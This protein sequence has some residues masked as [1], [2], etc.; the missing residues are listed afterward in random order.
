MSKRKWYAI[1]GV[2]AMHFGGIIYAWS[3]LSEPIG[4]EYAGVSA[5][6]LSF[7]FTVCMICFCLGGLLGGILQN[8]SSCKTILLI[9]GILFA[10]AFVGSSRAKTISTLCVTYGIMAGLASG[11]IY[12][13]VLSTVISWFQDK[14]GL[15][16]GILLMSF[17]FGSMILGSFF[18]VLTPEQVGAWRSTFVKLGI[19]IALVC[20]ISAFFLKK[21]P[22][23]EQVSASEDNQEG[24]SP[25][26]MLTKSSFWLFF[27]WAILLSASGLALISQASSFAGTIVSN[28][29]SEVVAFYVGLISIFNGLGRT[30]F[31]AVFDR[32]GRRTTMLI[33]TVSFLVSVTILIFAHLKT[34]I[35][36]MIIA[37][38]ATGFSYGGI[39]PTNSAFVY[40]EYG[41]FYYPQN[42]AIVNLNL[43]I[44]SFGGTVAGYLYDYSG[45]YLTT[46]IVML[47]AATI[48]L[49]IVFLMN[50][51]LEQG[52]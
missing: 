37:F 36:L 21:N 4:R 50:Y 49:L 30:F 35:I 13:T 43:L 34:S 48:S 16:S 3:I 23:S 20:F 29:S 40:S 6:K 26:E 25:A 41:K 42:L 38:M 14:Q 28:L 17:G 22:Y 8:K 2:A 10:F 18:T 24:I 7:I 44:A 51:K 11:L 39:T 15:M 47:M 46:F 19:V 27:L 31:G 9:S 52:N 32:I 45:A 12:N 1:V 5:A 33:I